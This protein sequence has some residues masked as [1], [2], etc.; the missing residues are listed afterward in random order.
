METTA[1]V[2]PNK[3]LVVTA[4]TLFALLLVS[5]I[6]FASENYYTKSILDSG[7]DTPGLN[8]PDGDNNN[9]SFTPDFVNNNPEYEFIIIPKYA[10]FVLSPIHIQYQTDS[11]SIRSPPLS[12]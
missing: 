7:Y 10:E 9:F 1:K 4:T 6:S 2:K 8:E 12:S 11:C 3:S 5:Q